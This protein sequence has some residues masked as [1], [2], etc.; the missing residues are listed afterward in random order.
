MIALRFKLILVRD[1]PFILPFN[2]S[3]SLYGFTLKAIETADSRIAWRLHNIKKDIKFVL[4]E[5]RAIG[6]RG[7]EWTVEKRDP[8]EI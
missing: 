5:P 6:K 2:Y 4:S 7:R 3:R 1:E 8:C